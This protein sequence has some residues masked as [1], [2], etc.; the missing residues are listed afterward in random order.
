MRFREH[1]NH[2]L[3]NL[4]DFLDQEPL[5]VYIHEV[6]IQVWKGKGEEGIAS[7]IFHYFCIQ[8]IITSTDMASG[9]ATDLLKFDPNNQLARNQLSGGQNTKPR[10]GSNE[11][12]SFTHPTM[13]DQ[14][15]ASAEKELEIGYT[16]LKLQAKLL[17]AEI[18]GVN[19]MGF[20][21]PDDEEVLSNLE[22]ISNGNVSMAVSILQ[23]PSVREVART[24][25]K[26]KNKCQDI[27]IEDFEAFVQWGKLAHPLL[28]P[29]EVRERLV[30]RKTLLE[31]ALPAS[32]EKYSAA[33]LAHIE[34]ELLQKKY[35]NS[36]TMFGDK[37]EDIPKENFFASEDN[38]AWD[39][40]ELAQALTS[41]DGVM[42]NPLSRQMFSESDIRMILAHPLGQRLKPIQ[43]AQSQLKKGVRPTTIDQIEKLGRIML[44]EQSIDAAPSRTA[45]DEFYAYL[46]T[47]PDSEQK[48]I[49]SLKIPARDSLNG[50][51]FDYTIG[52]S[53]RDAKANTTCFHKVRSHC[54]AVQL[55]LTQVPM[56]GWRFSFSSCG[57]PSKAMIGNQPSCW[58]VVENVVHCVILIK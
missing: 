8:K 32:M 48:T 29:D 47:I 6:L 30:K 33:A 40:D 9:I 49:R 10:K 56:T 55:K 35:V 36:E 27:M 23:P 39:M 31:A 46:V 57:V 53:V 7:P 14:D 3:V 21:S 37:V 24:I 2:V 15:W 52:E 13:T 18:A 1:K 4:Y 45:M 44:E 54:Y 25:L 20:T 50:Q 38:Y 22:A 51:A 16:A 41:N 26:A 19:G 28:G 43:Y 17:H 58:L 11:R 42:R 5:S 34:R 12:P